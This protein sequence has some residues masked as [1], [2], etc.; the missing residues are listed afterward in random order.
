MG[1]YILS[2]DICVERK[3]L[4][5]LRQSFISGRLY[6][7]AEAMS[8]YYKTPV[9]LVEFDGDKE[10]VLHGPSDITED[11]KVAPFT[12]SRQLAHGKALLILLCNITTSLILPDSASS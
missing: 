9:L 12:D 7:Q 4:S 1:D 2:P 6:N 8:K 5:D 11:I 3:S 10:F